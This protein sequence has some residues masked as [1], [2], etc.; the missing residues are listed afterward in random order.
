MVKETMVRYCVMVPSNLLERARQHTFKA[1]APVSCLLRRGLK[2]LLDERDRE[3]KV[4]AE[5]EEQE[6]K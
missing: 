5:L 6:A 2:A 4:L 3:E 1:G